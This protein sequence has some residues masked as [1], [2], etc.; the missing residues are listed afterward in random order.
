MAT[1]ST[2]TDLALRSALNTKQSEQERLA[3][4]VLSL[5]PQYRNVKSRQPE[6]G[7]DGGRDIEAMLAD[8]TIVYGAVGFKNNAND[9]TKQRREMAAK[10]RKD[11]AKSLKAKPDLKGFV[12]V[13]N[14]NPTVGMAGKLEAEA[15]ALGIQHVAIYDRNLLCST[16]NSTR[17]LIYRWQFLG[18]PL[19]DAE[20]KSFFEEFG[21]G[22]QNLLHRQHSEVT[23][24]LERI[25]FRYAMTRPLRDIRLALRFTRPVPAA[26]LADAAAVVSITS[27]PE[28]D[29]GWFIGGLA[30]LQHN[31]TSVSTTTLC[32]LND[33]A[34]PMEEVL[35]T[36][37]AYGPRLFDMNFSVRIQLMNPPLTPEFLEHRSC[38]FFVTRPLAKHI[39]S[40]TLEINGYQVVRFP[41]SDLKTRAPR[42]PWPP[43]Y[44]EKLLAMEWLEHDFYSGTI[45]LTSPRERS[46][47]R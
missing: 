24:A 21:A 30:D 9:D 38:R 2:T 5:N 13:T 35:R 29:H 42:V 8:G 44:H 7:S 39:Q 10:F 18:I 12:F 34:L 25:E 37:K 31:G 46:E 19:S 26:Q 28:G 3:N 1:S 47:R 40:A 41:I 4:A 27:L 14:V 16:L 33:H 11:L 22:I 17:G 32:R 6:G 45:D 15:K 20:Q 23:S 43:K 36:V